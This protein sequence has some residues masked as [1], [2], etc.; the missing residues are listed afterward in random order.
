MASDLMQNLILD[1]LSLHEFH[2][3]LRPIFF[4]KKILLFCSNTMKQL[5]SISRPEVN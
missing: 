5:E 2:E 3:K 1:K 4:L